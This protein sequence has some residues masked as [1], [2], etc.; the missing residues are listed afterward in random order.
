MNRKGAYQPMHLRRLI[1]AFQF[2]FLDVV[3][4]TWSQKLKMLGIH[5]KCNISIL[6]TGQLVVNLW[7]GVA[8]PEKKTQWKKDTLGV[9]YSSTKAVSAIVVAH[10]VDR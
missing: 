8:D 4:V 10:L 2:R 6:L 9:F 3:S 1:S 7:G 5:P